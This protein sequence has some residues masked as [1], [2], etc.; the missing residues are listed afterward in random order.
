M[1]PKIIHLTWFSG[2]EFPINI[3]KCID[4]WHKIL[5]DFKIKIW[6]MNMARALNIPF[7]NEAL[8]AHKWAFAGD[9]VRA[10]AVW[11]EGGIYMDTDIYLLKRF[12]EFLY[13]SMVFFVEIN[14]TE[15]RSFNPKGYIN[16]DGKCLKKDWLV[17][18]RQIQAAIFMG[19]KGHKCLEDIINYYKNIHFI[20]SDGTPNIQDISPSIYAKVLEK[21]GFLYKDKDQKLGDINI[22][23]SSYVAISKYNVFLDTFAIH[24][25]AHSWNPRTPWQLLKLKIRRIYEYMRNVLTGRRII[26]NI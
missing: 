1:I 2:D 15:W 25:A 6:D 11:S 17:R 26:H 20:K 19:E 16:K 18:G 23:A 4:T 21:Y 22:Y 9:V 24:L 10:Y 13:K 14:P 7:V 8:D 3:Q 12:D 5:P